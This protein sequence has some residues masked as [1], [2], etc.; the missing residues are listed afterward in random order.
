MKG[1]YFWFKVVVIGFFGKFFW[2][3]LVVFIVGLWVLYVFLL[4]RWFIDD[5]FIEFG[6]NFV[7]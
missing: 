3:L 4:W 6:F 7:G 1:F 5:E 2:F